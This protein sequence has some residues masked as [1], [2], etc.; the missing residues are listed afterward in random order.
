MTP[1]EAN[2]KNISMRVSNTQYV[3]FVPVRRQGC[4]WWSEYCGADLF[5]LPAKKLAWTALK[6][7]WEIFW[8]VLALALELSLVCI[9]WV[10]CS[11]KCPCRWIPETCLHF[12]KYA[13]DIMMTVMTFCWRLNCLFS[14]AE[15][16][17]RSD[18]L[19]E[20]QGVH[21]HTG[22]HF[23][24][25]GKWFAMY[26]SCTFHYSCPAVLIVPG[27]SYKVNES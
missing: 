20:F 17:R 7:S 23:S 16:R 11:S 26:L 2:H 6:T 9:S 13:F 12:S 10:W 19:S 15:Y 3:A 21:C 25:T 27:C 8:C 18:R 4:L 24:D 1:Y 5:S 22:A 14:I